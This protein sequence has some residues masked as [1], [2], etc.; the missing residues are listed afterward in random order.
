MKSFLLALPKRGKLKN[1]KIRREAFSPSQHVGKA[2]G[3]GYRGKEG[4]RIV[5]Q[6]CCLHIRLQILQTIPNNLLAVVKT[7]R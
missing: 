2:R 6:E 7:S 5:T 1:G 4:Y 3:D